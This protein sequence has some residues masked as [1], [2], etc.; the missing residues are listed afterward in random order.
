MRPQLPLLLA[1]GPNPNLLPGLVPFLER[2]QLPAI[3]L[4]IRSSSLMAR[5]WRQVITATFGSRAKPK[6]RGVGVR[7]PTVAG[8]TPMLAG[9]GFPKSHSA[10]PPIT[11]D[12]GRAC[13]ESAGF[14]F[15]AINGRRLG[16]P[17][18]R[19]TITLVGR[20][21]RRKRDLISRPAST[22]GRITITTWVRTNIVLSRPENSA[23]S[24][25]SPRLCPRNA[26]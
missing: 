16:F 9:P 15:R 22:I 25:S 17:G 4:F 21:C 1:N 7:T 2:D 26:T 12:V 3:Q 19:A 11:T 6:A 23:R 20:P 8:F 14:G 5:G 18:G 10:G 13:A 24:G